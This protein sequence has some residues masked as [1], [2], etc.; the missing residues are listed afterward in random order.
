[1][2][3]AR[4][5]CLRFF[6]RVATLRRVVYELETPGIAVVAGTALEH[7]VYLS[8]GLEEGVRLARSST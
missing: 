2:R 1:M 6:D 8:R 7:N 4:T 5:T 3:V